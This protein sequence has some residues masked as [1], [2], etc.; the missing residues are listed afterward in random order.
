MDMK[1]HAYA[2]PYSTADTTYTKYQQRQVKQQA[3]R[4][5]FLLHSSVGIVIVVDG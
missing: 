3:E 2:N 1:W 4:G 5:A